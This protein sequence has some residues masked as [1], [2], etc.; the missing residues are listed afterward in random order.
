MFIFIFSSKNLFY[1]YKNKVDTDRNESDLS[2]E[3]IRI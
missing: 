3:T 2:D 1:E